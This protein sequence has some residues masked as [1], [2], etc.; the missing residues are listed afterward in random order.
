MAAG[1]AGLLTV[2]ASAGCAFGPPNDEDQGTPPKL[3]SPSVSDSDDGGA[4]VQVIAKRLRVPWGIAF[5]PD[6]SALVTERDSGKILKLKS[7]GGSVAKP[8]TVQTVKASVHDG[9]GGLLGI[10]VSPKYATDKT[11]FVYYSTADDNRIAKFTLGKTPKPIVTGIPHSSVHNGG[12]LAFGPDGYLY[13]GT[14]D[15]TNT[16][17]AQDKS[18]LGGKILRM[19]TD[20]KPAPGNPFGDSLVYSYGHR[21]VQGLAWDR[22]KQL[23]ATEF[24][25]DKWDEVNLI[26]PG[27]NYG[28]PKAEGKS[29]NS[30]Y[31]NPLETFK[32]SQAS[33]SGAA[34]S[35]SILVTGCLAGQRVWLMQL[36]GKGGVLGAPQH[37]L[38]KQYGRLRA[39][40]AAPD[41][42][43]WV[44][45]SNR[46]G[47]G[48]PIADDDRILR[49]VIS[50]GNK[51]DKS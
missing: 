20:G 32:P 19:T 48:S 43:L 3:P 11:V 6:G 2:L 26:K 39:V 15:G 8:T 10:A 12:A 18:S 40:V 29:S 25:Q 50:G 13:A 42:T 17:L 34:I 35:G 30:A 21:N 4:T 22:S 24:G 44:S 51:V 36:D 5:L 9:E 1:L 7:S 45:T 14:G 47:R 37:T 28:W 49:L 33:C 41:G 16:G 31:T 46:D 27:H 38:D 23:Y